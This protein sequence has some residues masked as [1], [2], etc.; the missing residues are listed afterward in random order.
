MIFA[1]PADEKFYEEYKECILKVLH[2]F[3]VPDLPVL[4]NMSI[5]HTEPKAILPY[6]AK[7]RIDCENVS[8]FIDD[9]A[10]VPAKR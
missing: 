8:L 2:E 10:V 1:K 4:Y 9:Y 6:G 7:A 3:G 5:G